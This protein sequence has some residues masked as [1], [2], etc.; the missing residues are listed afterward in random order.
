MIGVAASAVRPAGLDAGSSQRAARTIIGMPRDAVKAGALGAD[1]V[2]DPE[3]AGAMAGLAD[4]RLGSRTVVGHAGPTAQIPVS[5]GGGTLLGVDAV[6]AKATLPSATG[7]ARAAASGK[8]PT[9]R[10][11]LGV[12]RPGIAPLTPGVEDEPDDSD[13]R[14]SRELGATIAPF[15][16]PP[17]RLR[18]PDL[19]RARPRG[20]EPRRGGAA[21]VGEKPPRRA[22]VILGV[23][24]GLAIAAVLF[25]V[26]WPSA[27][28][29]T[30]RAKV[31][32][33]GKEGVGITCPSCP[34][35]TRVAIGEA[36]AA[37]A[38]HTATLALPTGLSV[39]ENHFKVAIE[40]PHGGRRESVNVTV[41][42][43]YRIRPD[44]A[45]LQG[46]KPSLQIVVEAI[47]ATKVSLAGRPIVLSNGRAIETIDVT[48]LVLGNADEARPLTK[49]ITYVVTPPDGPPETGAVN[50]A[51]SIA[52]LHVDA[53]GPRVTIDT[54]SFVLAG[55]TM[56]GAE[57][58]A[59][60]KPIAVRPDGSFAQVMNVSAVGA[61]TIEVR[62][63]TP[64]M[65]P[66]L[67]A[68]AVR[69]VDSLDAAAKELA[70][71]ATLKAADLMSNAS[72]GKPIV[73]AGQVVEARKQG[74]QTVMLL[75]VDGCNE[76]KAACR[77]RLVQ[78]DD[79]GAREGDAIR[80]F[81]TVSREATNGAPPE[82][83]VD[84]TRKGLK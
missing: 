55:R 26:L 77:V 21:P 40:R 56:K 12:A 10:T 51:V 42:V 71:Q 74:Y 34:E 49:Q 72:V 45:T 16:S 66:R 47:G 30:A 82:V 20:A 11:L 2:I 31:D 67:Y 41:P 65:A 22:L 78:G 48:D 32:Q 24:G 81:G 73:L 17:L 39:G 23:A 25:A 59:A 58:L 36:S 44:L 28:P 84:F 46:D 61:T 3:P 63:K 13:Q 70:S 52:P 6:N 5:R 53:P 83:L 50:I 15:A 57:V 29:I 18:A 43:G 1:T 62:A 33:E 7:K 9:A 19:P 27:P 4:E 60:G 35:G 80:V 54:A 8:D 68:I 38:N 14:V 64:G 37:I 69:R 79:R 76:P 75:D